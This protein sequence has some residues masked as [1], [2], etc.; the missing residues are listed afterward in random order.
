[1]IYAFYWKLL[2][3]LVGTT[4]DALI[5]FSKAQ[6]VA[7]GVMSRRS[8]SFHTQHLFILSGTERICCNFSHEK[9]PSGMFFLTMHTHDCP[10]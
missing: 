7:C 6:M 1:M 2:Y 3:I 8:A 4:G 9:L 5:M 10:P